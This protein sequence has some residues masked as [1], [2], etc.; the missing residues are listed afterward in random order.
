[1]AA[2]ITDSELRHLLG[3]LGYGNLNG[4]VWFIGMEEG[5][6]GEDNIR[7]RLKFEVI[8]DCFEA[9]KKLG[10]FHHHT[11]KKSIQRTWGWISYIML[12]LQGES[13]DRES[14]RKYQVEQLGR[15]RGKTFLCE[16]M[17]LPKPKLS[18]YDYLDL[19]PQFLNRED[20]YSKVKPKRIK[21]IK[22]LL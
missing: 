14:K 3:F 13:G 7:V 2:P 22:D 5:G 1:M 10:I 15:S 6:G 19:I 11:G 16:L 18:A 4:D 21:K 9:H 20:Y 17:P 12:I 8:E